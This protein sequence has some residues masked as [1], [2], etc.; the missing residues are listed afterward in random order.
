[1]EILVLVTAKLVKWL[2]WRFKQIASLPS[3]M[4]WNLSKPL[5]I[6]KNI[7]YPRYQKYLEEHYSKLPVLNS[8]EAQIVEELEEKG[9]CITSLEKLDIPNTA[10]FLEATKK[11][12][13]E[14]TEVSLLPANQSKYEI[15]A[16]SAQ[17]IK[18][19]DIFQWGL[20]DRLLKIAE[21][22]LGLP[23]AYDGLLFILS[24]ADGK[25]IGP[26]A[27]HRDREDRRMI[28]VGIYL[29]DVNEDG[30]PF[31]YMQSEAN[32]LVCNS[33]KERYKSVFDK[34]L[35]EIF[36]TTASEGIT[37]C[38]GL[39]G[40]VI[41][42]DAARH[43][44]RGMPPTKLNRSALFFSYFSRRPW[45]PF[46]CQRSPLSK[47]D[48]D[49]FTAGMSSEQRACVNWKDELPRIVRWLPKSLI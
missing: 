21:R 43:Y 36:A 9:I 37:T 34:D 11:L 35:K 19:K 38:T 23:V 49:F 45:H 31:Q 47:K 24:I 13:Q 8:M 27:W 25:E 39:A 28:K 40:T 22:Y 41:F 46:F 33:V 17:L 14:L 18:Y 15:H 26:R 29:N 16:T 32:L 7:F 48:L 5:F 44:H 30:G 3:Q 6:E 20:N 2:T 10:E 42:V 4:A 1:M 12:S